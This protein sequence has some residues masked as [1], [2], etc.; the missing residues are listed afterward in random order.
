MNVDALVLGI[1]NDFRCDDGVGVAAARRIAELRIAGVR[2]M[3]DVG[4]P[5]SVLDAWT[6]V[7]LVVAVDAATC[8]GAQPGRIR[9]WSTGCHAASALVSSHGFGLAQTLSLGEALGR[10]PRRLVIFTVD[11]EDVSRQATLTPAVAGVVPQVIEAIITE[12]AS[13]SSTARHRPLRGPPKPQKT[14]GSA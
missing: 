6:D 8:D 12:L 1:G 7:S 11:V 2:V 5:A 14:F 3:I 13:D 10:L 9:R 4:D